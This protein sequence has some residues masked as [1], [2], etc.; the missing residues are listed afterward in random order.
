MCTQMGFD[1]PNLCTLSQKIEVSYKIQRP[2]YGT[3]PSASWTFSGSK[4]DDFEQTI[5]ILSNLL[6]NSYI[7]SSKSMQQDAGFLPYDDQ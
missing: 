4:S 7:L 3:K 2:S 1:A 6:Q 5:A